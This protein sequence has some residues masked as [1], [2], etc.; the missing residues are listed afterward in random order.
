MPSLILHP[1]AA[2]LS[3]CLGLNPQ[4]GPLSCPQAGDLEPQPAVSAS[5]PPVHRIDGH[6]AGLGAGLRHPHQAAPRHPPSA[7]P[8]DGVF[9]TSCRCWHFPP[10]NQMLTFSP[11][12]SPMCTKPGRDLFVHV[13][14]PRAGP[15]AAV[16]S[17]DG[18]DP[19]P[20]GDSQAAGSL[21]RCR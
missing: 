14:V 13:P 19:P 6:H 18:R 2:L 21:G 11:P 20:G 5:C 17:R 9:P 1:P 7:A 16:P 8:A 3:L 12:Q 15:A 4:L 10:F